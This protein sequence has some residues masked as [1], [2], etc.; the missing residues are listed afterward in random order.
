M[1]SY[2]FSR[3]T[4]VALLGLSLFSAFVVYIPVAQYLGPGKVQ[5]EI[6][7]LAPVLIFAW[8]MHLKPVRTVSLADGTITFKNGFRQTS[9]RVAEV[10][11]IRPWLNL[12][13][14]NF[15]L[16]HTLGSELMMN[17]PSAV[18]IL[19]RDIKRES[20]RFVTRGIPPPPGEDRHGG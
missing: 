10:E 3:G 2:D 20:P 16:E 18:A 8:Y 13:S 19:A 1:K 17:D 7:W 15:V 12:S 5:A 4:R 11:S 14:T 6:A 9:V